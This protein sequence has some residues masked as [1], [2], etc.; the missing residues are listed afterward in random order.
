MAL[1]PG[2]RCSGKA[3]WPA[4]GRGQGEGRRFQAP[5]AGACPAPSARRPSATYSHFHRNWPWR[6]VSRR[7]WQPSCPFQT[8]G[9]CCS[10]FPQPD[11]QLMT[12]CTTYTSDY[13]CPGFLLQHLLAVWLIFHE[14]RGREGMDLGPPCDGFG[15][16]LETDPWDWSFGFHS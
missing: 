11:G 12:K 4:Q 3:K 7:I 15:K 16:F 8:H 14:C 2:H 10:L 6:K 9:A 13:Y 1:T 5:C